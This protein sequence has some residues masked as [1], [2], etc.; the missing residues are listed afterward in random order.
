[1]S[2]AVDE[3]ASRWPT[4]FFRNLRALCL[5]IGVVSVA[6]LT[7]ISVLPRM[8]DPVLTRRVSLMTTRVPG[9][10]ALRVEALVTEPI[11]DFLQDIEEVKKLRSVSRPGFSTIS[12][13]LRDEIV[14]PDK[15][16]SEVR[17]KINDVVAELPFDAHRPTFEELDVRAYALIISVVWDRNDPPNWTLLRRYAKRLEDTL[18]SVSGTETIDRFADPGEEIT[19]MID[20]DATAALGLSATE[21][22]QQLGGSDAKEAAGLFRTPKQQMTIEVANQFKWSGE[23]VETIIRSDA[24]GKTVRL[25][26]IATV[27][28]GVPDPLPRYALIDGKPAVT[29]GVMVRRNSRIDLWRSKIELSLNAFQREIPTGLALDISLDQNHYVAQRLSSLLGNL[30][31]GVIAV[32]VVIWGLMGFRSAMVVAMALPLSGFSVLFGLRLLEIPIHQMSITGMIIAIGLLIDNAIVA[33][34]EVSAEMKL[35]TTPQTAV[36]RVIRHL[37]IPLLGSTITTALAFAPIA[38]MPGP[39]GEFVGSISISVI[40]AVSA[41][42]FFSLS[43]IPVVAAKFLAAGIAKHQVEDKRSPFRRGMEDGFSSKALK[44]AYQRLLMFLLGSPWRAIAISLVLP[45]LGFWMFQKLPEQFFPAADRDQFYVEVELPIDSRISATEAASRQVN[46]LL[47]KHGAKKVSWFFGESAPVFYYNIVGARRGAANFAAAIVQ[48]DSSEG[49]REQINALQKEAD[50]VVL[51]ARVLMRQLEQGPPFTAPIEARLF[52]PDLEQLRELGEEVRLALSRCS[53][54]THTKSMLAETLVNVNLQVD[55]TASRLVG[56]DPKQISRQLFGQ[57]EGRVA[58]QIIE[59]TETIPVVVRVEDD[60]RET[61]TGLQSLELTVGAHRIPLSSVA[62]TSLSPQVAG[63]TRL[64]RRRM[65]EVAGYIEAGKLPSVTLAELEAELDRT[66]FRLP[67]GYTL[68]YGG[69]A[70]QRNEAVGNL[71]ANVG[72]LIVAMIAVLVLS[73]RSFRLA[74]VILAVAVLSMGLGMIGLYVGGYPFGF[75]AIIGTMGLIGVAINDSIV[76][77]AALR[78]D[79]GLNAASDLAEYNECLVRVTTRCTRHVLATTLT[80]I[81]GFTP[82]ILAGGRFWPPLA[83]T[84][85]GGVSGATLIALFFVPASYRL[86]CSRVR[87]R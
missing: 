63:I 2:K 65:N 52:G 78:Q 18:Q 69:E 31:L 44:H 28:R 6:G 49:I 56:L 64:S 41:S 23:L 75:V 3:P 85:A 87:L 35:G 29:L 58:G 26:D 13:E 72:V 62:V 8:E 43:V 7:S 46:E 36:D 73:F 50:H 86:L 5:L 27:R 51:D 40:L 55:E 74:G 67:P 32:T 42:L 9:A 84:I 15:V 57:L 60:R 22:A 33:V 83:I 16:W 25:G 24:D 66:G 48:L 39:A 14:E 17:S 4:F 45:M 79:E 21:V 19:V 20:P 53:E 37:A 77:L 10:D 68:E 76:V 54:V 71:M 1:M 38:M 80:T 30:L 34:D 61:F 70:S 81:A 12:I 47:V 82:L 59:D 11:E